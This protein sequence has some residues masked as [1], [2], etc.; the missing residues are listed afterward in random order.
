M[1]EN[2]EY[3]L[4]ESRKMN[5]S[6]DPE[7]TFSNRFGLCMDY[8]VLLSVFCESVGI[9]CFVVKGYPIGTRKGKQESLGNSY[10]A[11]NYVK[12]GGEWKAVDPTWYH[13]AEPELHFLENLTA[14]QYEH[15]PEKR[16]LRANPFGPSNA[17]ELSL[18]PVVKQTTM[19]ILY[20]GN[21]DRI[22]SA[23]GDELEV[24]LYSS[25]ETEL[26][27]V[28]D[29]TEYNH[30]TVTMSFCLGCPKRTEEIDVKKI[31]H[32]TRGLNRLKIPLTSVLA[33]YTL[34]NEDF[35][36]AF[37]ASPE[38]HRSAAFTKM[39]EFTGS[40]SYLDEVYRYF[41]RWLSGDP[42]TMTHITKTLRN[43]PNW[44]Y[45]RKTYRNEEL[46]WYALDSNRQFAFEFGKCT[47]GGNKPIIVIKIDSEGNIT[48][49]PK[50]MLE[51]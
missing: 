6:N 28:V 31:Y 29:S 7:F 33:R 51:D 14:Y 11:W 40:S 42:T 18:C 34:K 35:E 49:G 4:E 27:L 45:M 10:H 5:P 22:T 43:H 38:R 15:V 26:S 48:D 23:D 13:S 39:T 8:A 50:L 41:E 37:I 25:K 24:V 12:V 16:Q 9:P 47:I 32:L 44:D 20:T 17:K 36:I 19:D 2:L 46:K 1:S 3:K 30:H 21:F